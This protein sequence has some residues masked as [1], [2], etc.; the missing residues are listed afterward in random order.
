ML[1]PEQLAYC[2]D[3]MIKLYSQLDEAIVRDIARRITKTGTMTETGRLQI[4]ALQDVGMLY[5]DI[6]KTVSA[7]TGK[8]EELLQDLF[9]NAALWSVEYDIDIYAANGL[10][11]IPLNMSPA[12][13]QT[14]EA[15][16]IKTNGNLQNLTRT[17]AITSQTSF[18]NACTLAEMKVESGA[19]SYE[20]AISAAIS[21]IAKDG[22]YVLYPSGHRDRIDVAVRRNVMTGLGQ[23]TGRICLGYAQ[24][25]GC[26]LMEITAHCGA[27][28]SHAS[29]QGQIVSLSGR[30]GYLSLDDIGYGS[31]DGF[32]GWNCRHDWY[33]YFEGS[34]RMYS[35]KDIEELNAANIKFPDGSMHTYYEA[36][37]YQRTCERKIRETKRILAAQDECIKTTSSESLRNAM[38]NDFDKFAVKL[39]KQEANLTDFC[40]KTGLLKDNARAQ[41]YGFSRSTAQKAVQAN[42]KS[43]AKSNNSGTIKLQINLFDTKD[44]LYV[45][46]FSMEEEDGFENVCM[47]G[48]P[49]SVQRIVNGVAKNYSAKEFAEYLK[50]S[51]EYKGTD[52]KLLA[53][54][55]G[56]GNNS[57]AQQLSKELG[58]RVK[59][60]DDDVYYAVEEGIAFVGASNRNTGKWRIFDKGVEIFE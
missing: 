29:W 3:D 36:E 57:F 58:I 20:Q 37:Q 39:K 35:D 59:A 31:G 27:R 40:N 51:K 11:P 19:F 32:K 16:Y 10:N 13:M 9:E 55:V 53:C 22:A 34:T 42:K 45:E 6:V 8:S 23:T 54:S 18:I 28:P 44:P 43:I 38:Q 4:N 7:Y 52:L 30:K 14:L 21:Q 49:Q 17:T 5:D 50:L 47:H 60:P 56:K 1:T 25:M 26:D 12:A 46:A 2:A 33:P 15:G 24:D 48:S 41:T